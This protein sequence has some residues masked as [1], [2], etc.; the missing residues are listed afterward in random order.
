MTSQEFRAIKVRFGFSHKLLF[1]KVGLLTNITKVTS[2][3][4]LKYPCV[5]ISIP[6]HPSPQDCHSSKTWYTSVSENGMVSEHESSKA[7]KSRQAC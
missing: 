2:I 4:Q 3:S 6:H 5:P 1:V 7:T